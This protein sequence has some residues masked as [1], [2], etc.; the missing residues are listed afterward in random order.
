MVVLREFREWPERGVDWPLSA[1]EVG[2]PACDFASRSTF[3][4]LGRRIREEGVGARVRGRLGVCAISSIYK[5]YA[6]ALS[7]LK[8][9]SNLAREQHN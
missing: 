4:E 3:W 5:M 7:A 2:D 9:R 6:S 1:T 8:I